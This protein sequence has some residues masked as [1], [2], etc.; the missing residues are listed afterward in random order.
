MPTAAPQSQD[1]KTEGGRT[2]SHRLGTAPSS[3]RVQL[4]AGSFID[5][6]SGRGN[7]AGQ[8]RNAQAGPSSS[9]GSRSGDASSDATARDAAARRLPP[10]QTSD[11]AL[12]AQGIMDRREKAQEIVAVQ[13]SLMQ[14]RP[15]GRQELKKAL[16]RL[17]VP[18]WLQVNQERS[19]FHLCGYPLC[20]NRL[21][22]SR[23]EAAARRAGQ[24]RISVS[25]RAIER[26]TS[27]EPGGRNNFC[28]KRCHSA[29][30]WVRRWV[31]EPGAADA[32]GVS[33][34]S[35]SRQGPLLDPTSRGGIWEALI[36]RREDQWDE[37]ELLEDLE[38]KGELDGWDG[39]GGGS[40]SSVDAHDKT[41]SAATPPPATTTTAPALPPTASLPPPHAATAA[42]PAAPTSL[43]SSLTISER[44]KGDNAQQ[45]RDAAAAARP[46][47]R[48]YH[49]ARRG[50]DDDDTFDSLLSP[51]TADSLKSRITAVQQPQ[52]SV[53]GG[54][55]VDVSGGDDDDDDV[56]DEEDD[57]DDD[58]T[59]AAP[60][61]DP[62]AAARQRE[63]Q[64][65][66]DE[67]FSLR[68][69]LRK[70]EEFDE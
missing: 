52:P 5:A 23:D 48:T 10:V 18:H 55:G 39:Y 38:D 20:R 35:S 59:T 25:R 68:E 49:G 13:E 45:Q 1:K 60:P 9:T 36:H 53:G 21:D 3:L 44:Q 31:L 46:H 4:P 70:A 40:G 33:A 34:G 43:L 22:A 63:E 66:F 57:D 11:A 7:G 32:G 56:D 69:T 28:S 65:I 58:A 19:L 37:I 61:L 50:D 62:A 42:S 51:G 24:F 14:D 2:P 67:A 16:T 27:D 64:R 15:I 54:F 17:A 47:P 12:L 8:G 30:E 26:D 6:F 29:S 41:T